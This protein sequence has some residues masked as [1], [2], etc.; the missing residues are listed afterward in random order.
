MHVCRSKNVI[1]TLGEISVTDFS[2]RSGA[3]WMSQPCELCFRVLV[4]GFVGTAG[5]EILTWL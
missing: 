2:K 3:S 4:S 1:F 5:T